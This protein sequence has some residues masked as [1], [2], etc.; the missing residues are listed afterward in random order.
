MEATYGNGWAAP[1]GQRG[2]AVAGWSGAE[3]LFRAEVNLDAGDGTGRGTVTLQGELVLVTRPMADQALRRAERLADLVVLDLR[4]VSSIDSAGLQVVIDT[5]L[6]Q[7]AAGRRLVVITGSPQVRR[8]L[9]LAGVSN[10]LE[11][12]DDVTATEVRHPAI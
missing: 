2:F 12:T 8:L 11:I 1:G 3:A 4:G 9:E 7:R 10:Q 5:N 6:R